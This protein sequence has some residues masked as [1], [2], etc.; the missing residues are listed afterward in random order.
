ML[1][2]V[3]DVEL[4]RAD[5]TQAQPFVFSTAMSF[6]SPLESAAHFAAVG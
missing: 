4:E 6:F 1:V 2:V 3:R 5:R